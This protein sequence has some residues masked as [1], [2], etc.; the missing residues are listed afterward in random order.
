[1][2]VGRRLQDSAELM[3]SVETR[4]SGFAREAGT[5]LYGTGCAGVRVNQLP[6]GQ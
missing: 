4:G 1:M 6:M 5:A 3:G 2:V